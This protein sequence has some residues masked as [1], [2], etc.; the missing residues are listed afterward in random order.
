MRFSSQKTKIIFR[1]FVIFLL[2]P[3]LAC[4][5]PKNQNSKTSLSLTDSEK[6]ILLSYGRLLLSKNETEAQKTQFPN[7]LKII[8]N[9]LI[10][11]VFSE[12]GQMMATHR[13]DNSHS[14]IPEK[15]QVGLHDVMTLYKMD[16]QQVYLHMMLVTDTARLANFGIKGLFDNKIY[17]PL[18]TGIAYEKNGKR[19]EIN[20]LEALVFDLSASETRKYLVRS[21]GFSPMQMPYQNDLIVEIYRVLHFGESYPDRKMSS[22]FRGHKIFTADDV[23]SDELLKRLKLV[24]H[25][26][27]NNVINGE[28]TYKYYPAE[29]LYDNSERTMIRSTMAVWVLN[30]LAIF[31]NDE[32]LKKRGEE[33]IQYYLEDYFRMT[34]SLIAGK[35]L[36]RIEPI[37]SGDTVQNRFTTASFLVAAIVER[38][39]LKKYEKEV[40]LL[41][42]WAMAYQNQEGLIWTPNAQEQYFMPGQLL[43]AISSLY[44]QTK[45]KKY[46]DFF[47]KTYSVYAP[48]L[49]AM[50]EF[51][52]KLYTPLAPAWFTQPFAKMYLLT[53]DEKYRDMVFAIND[54]VIQWYAL[55]TENEIYYDYDGI[56]AP[57][58]GYFGNVSV[59]AASLESLTD[60]A[61]VAKKSGDFVRTKKY[62]HGIKQTVAYLLRLQFTPE[63]SYYFEHRE[64]VLGG[65]KTDL[66]NNTVWCDNVWH[67]TSAFIKIY[68]NKLL[69]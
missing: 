55:N 64:R 68:Q 22:Y 15:I 10:L 45:E 35:V 56:L 49:K 4:Q 33:G 36:P 11:T 34:E 7:S 12:D 43:V 58:A 60:A 5:S 54:R 66:I 40:A 18:V 62:T 48:Q 32:K 16:P 37:E 39:E 8:T 25:W 42:D 67:A 50:M 46:L 28:V 41:I 13:V 38:Q 53:G 31:L 20:P 14:S 51:G 26:Y 1:L 17:E 65:F 21:L 59:T 61:I 57:K 3:W 24:G 30:K 69:P 44:E 2:F 9:P 52:N 29:G 63:N 47:E 23:N 6:N 19:V 27:E